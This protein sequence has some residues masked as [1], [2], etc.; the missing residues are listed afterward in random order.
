MGMFFQEIRQIFRHEDL[1]RRGTTTA[2][3]PAD[4][5]L[6]RFGFVFHGENLVPFFGR[7]QRAVFAQLFGS[8]Q[9]LSMALPRAP[10]GFH[11]AERGCMRSTSRNV[12]HGT[13]RF[14]CADM[15]RLV[16]QTQ[17]RSSQTENG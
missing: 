10:G 5:L 17:P 16:F 2:D 14:A 3:Y 15:L 8:R 4:R 13:K 6:H 7:G 9:G 1:L 11:F 12:R